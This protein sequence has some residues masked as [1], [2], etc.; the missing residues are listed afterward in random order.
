[1]VNKKA[2]GMP[3][4]DPQQ[5][6]A[7]PPQEAS[8]QQGGSLQQ[9]PEL[10]PLSAYPGDIALRAKQFI[11]KMPDETVKEMMLRLYLHEL[12]ANPQI[13]GN[14]QAAM[15]AIEQHLMD[16]APPKAA[17]KVAS[18]SPATTGHF[19]IIQGTAIS[20]SAEALGR[21]LGALVFRAAH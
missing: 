7:Q 13:E 11:D 9:I 17:K 10:M 5:M 14:P 2:D 15:A 3:M 12:M 1:M 16:A 18:E 8:P 21:A 6:G 19:D 4:G 20:G